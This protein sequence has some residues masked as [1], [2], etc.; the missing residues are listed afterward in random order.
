MSTDS[1]MPHLQRIWVVDDD[2]SVRFVLATALRDAGYDVDGFDSAAAAL[3]ALGARGAPDLL[4]TDVRMPGDDGL[5]LLD[6]LKATHPQLPVIVMSAYTDVASTAGAFRGGAHEFLSKPFDLDDA[7]ALAARALPDAEQETAPLPESGAPAQGTPHLIGD[8]PAMRALFRAIGRLAQAPLSVLING[9]TG[10]GKEL[11]ARAL[12]QESPRARKP[13]VALNT[14]AIPAELLESE[15]FGHEAGAFTGAQKRH[16]GRFEQADGG[17]LFLDEIGDMP[18]PL[19]T[20][21]LRVLAEGEFFRVGGREL[22]RVD[23]RVIAAT[24]QH[25]ETLVAEGRFRAD[26]LHRLDVVRL[27]LPPLRERLADVPQLADNF[28]AAATRKLDIAPKRFSH[29]AQVQLQSYAWPGNV[30]ELENVCW[31]LA[32]LAPGDVISGA[33]LEAV[34]PR[35]GIRNLPAT[36]AGDWDEALA[37]WVRARL[38]EGVDGLHAEARERFDRTLLEVALEFT[39]GRRAEAATRL[40]VGRNTVTR[41]LGPGRKR[42]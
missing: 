13:F 1:A 18:L 27:Q 40:G 25:L 20:R 5:V 32:A 42:R 19:Q 4:F 21:L 26:L 23:V 33:D 38:A 37:G 31:R 30:R 10:T 14:A 3:Q 9:E 41:K 11:V 28:L 12:H 34:L 24:H 35:G 7:V 15:L 17:T 36:S 22:I 2:R 6:K 16:I 8:T 29:A 39:Q